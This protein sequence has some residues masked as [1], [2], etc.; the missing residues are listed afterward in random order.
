[1]IRYNKLKIRALKVFASAPGAWFGPGEV[2]ERLEFEPPRAVWTY[3]KR[4]WSFGLLERCH[5]NRGLLRYRI[6]QKGMS[7]LRWLLAAKD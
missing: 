1:M 7:R 2:A 5:D 6:N 4:L 3:L